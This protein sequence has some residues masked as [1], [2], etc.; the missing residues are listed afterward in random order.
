MK[1]IIKK[2]KDVNY[3]KKIRRMHFCNKFIKI[4]LQSLSYS[5]YKTQIYNNILCKSLSLKVLKKG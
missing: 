4:D 1:R 3:G 5:F 2:T